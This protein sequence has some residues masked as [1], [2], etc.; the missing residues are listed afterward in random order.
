MKRTNYILLILGVFLALTTF[1]GCKKKK[2]DPSPQERILGKW[3]IT[4]WT[5]RE[6]NNVFDLY[7]IMDACAK[8]D[9]WEFRTGGV[10]AINEGATKCSPSDPQE[11]TGNYTLSADGKTL[12]ITESGS[13]TVFEVVELSSTTMKL[14]I[15]QTNNGVTVTSEIT[16]TKI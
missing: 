13:N 6:G 16:F 10:L 3:R 12:T 11:T 5:I 7:A 8:D 15:T 2:Q 9:Y 4:A 1:S 14:K